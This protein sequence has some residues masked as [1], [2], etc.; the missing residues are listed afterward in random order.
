MA[1]KC[2]QDETTSIKDNSFI[3]IKAVNYKYIERFIDRFGRVEREEGLFRCLSRLDSVSS[4]PT[5]H[6]THAQVA[7]AIL[8]VVES[9][10][11]VWLT[12]ESECPAHPM[13]ISLRTTELCS[14]SI[15]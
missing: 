13:L 12:V 5:S 2:R 11:G 10:I 3:N 1:C 8:L 4:T 7:T 14:S 9:L 15:I 6:N